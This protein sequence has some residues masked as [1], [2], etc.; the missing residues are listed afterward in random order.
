[1]SI[2]V[3][4]Q[5][6]NLD[7]VDRSHDCSREGEPPVDVGLVP[8]CVEYGGAECSEADDNHRA[9]ADALVHIGS[10]NTVSHSELFYL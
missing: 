1:M 8:D 4:T 9:R 3:M 6:Y 7:D 2:S 10:C 5:E